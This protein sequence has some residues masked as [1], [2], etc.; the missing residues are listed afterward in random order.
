MYQLDYGTAQLRSRH[1]LYLENKK[2]NK[3]A[4]PLTLK[5]DFSYPLDDSNKQLRKSILMVLE[6]ENN[7]RE[8]ST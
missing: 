4:R 8:E 3:A 5:N 6:S 7:C 1:E 2:W